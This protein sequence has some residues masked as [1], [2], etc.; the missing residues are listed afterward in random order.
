MPKIKAKA[1][2]QIC[3]IYIVKSNFDKFA[4]ARSNFSGVFSH[5]QLRLPD[6]N[7]IFFIG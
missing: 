3:G 1:N 4:L 6:K 5:I 7:D 2:K